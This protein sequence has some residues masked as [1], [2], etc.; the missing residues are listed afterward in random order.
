MRKRRFLLLDGHT[1]II[2]KQVLE[3]KRVILSEGDQVHIISPDEKSFGDILIIPHFEG[4]NTTTA[5]FCPHFS[6]PPPCSG[7]DQWVEF[8]RVNLLSYYVKKGI[9]LCGIGSGACILYSEVLKG[10]LDWIDGS[11]EPFRGDAANFKFPN[12]SWDFYRGNVLGLP[13]LNEDTV[14]EIRRHFFSTKNGGGDGSVPAEVPLTP[15]RTP[16]LLQKRED[17]P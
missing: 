8:F 4:F 11:I 7:S 6:V 14:S 10:K 16:L 15:P 2:N 3:L 1:P 9:P 12:G 5:A 13:E 17:R